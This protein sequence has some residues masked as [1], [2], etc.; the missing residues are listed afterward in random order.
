MTE[1]VTLRGWVVMNVWTHPRPVVID[2]ASRGAITQRSN[3]LMFLT[4][5]P[6]LLARLAELARAVSADVPG[7]RIDMRYTAPPA[8]LATE[9]G[10]SAL[11][12]EAWML[13]LEQL[14]FTRARGASPWDEID[15]PYESPPSG[16]R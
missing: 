16:E 8:E 10:A 12:D 4:Q 3:G 9:P 14:G 11:F 2:P 7:L 15:S 1:P 6:Q 13:R 5:Q